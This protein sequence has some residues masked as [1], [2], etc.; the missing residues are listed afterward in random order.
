MSVCIYVGA[1]DLSSSACVR[2]E[3]L[4]GFISRVSSGGF[5]PPPP[6]PEGS[7]AKCLTDIESIRANRRTEVARK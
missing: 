6:L 2:V 5:H 4:S 7:G 1:R 3:R